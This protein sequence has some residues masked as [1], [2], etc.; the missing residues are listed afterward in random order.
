MANADIRVTEVCQFCELDE[1]GQQL[2]K[3]VMAQS[4]LS[5]RAYHRMLKL[6]Y[7]IADLAG[8]ENIQF[9]YLADA[10]QSHAKGMMV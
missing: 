1:A 8:G 2:I 10:L 3:A 4:Q 7:T 9:V 6:A 5:A